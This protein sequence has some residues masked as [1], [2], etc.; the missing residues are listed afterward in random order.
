MLLNFFKFIN[1]S[2]QEQKQPSPTYTS[3]NDNDI[4]G[5]YMYPLNKNAKSETIL[6]KGS[7]EEER[8]AHDQQ[9]CFYQEHIDYRV[10]EL[11]DLIIQA[12]QTPDFQTYAQAEQDYL[13]R[14]KF[15]LLLADPNKAELA[16]IAKEQNPSKA[17]KFHRDLIRKIKDEHPLYWAPK[18]IHRTTTTVPHN[19]PETP[20]NR[21]STAQELSVPSV[22][23]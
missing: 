7:K 23:L 9:I 22:H 15:R 19:T 12:E 4:E 21:P 13:A 10:E 1:E 3:F 16:I 6:I 17:E 8:I 20:D 14:N 5:A 2:K 11:Q 18:P